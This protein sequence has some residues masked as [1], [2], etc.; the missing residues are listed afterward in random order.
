MSTR[1]ASKYIDK[2]SCFSLTLTY[3]QQQ[4]SRITCFLQTVLSNNFLIVSVVM[5]IMV[6]NTLMCNYVSCFTIFLFRESKLNL[7]VHFYTSRKVNKLLQLEL[8]AFVTHITVKI[9]MPTKLTRAKNYNCEK[10][11]ILCLPLKT[12]RS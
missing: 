7:Y 3:L 4:I 1:Y 10:E 11:C 12:H 5:A 8:H 2:L 6:G 9:T